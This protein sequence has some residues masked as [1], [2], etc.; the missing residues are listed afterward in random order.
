MSK[1]F[2]SYDI[3]QEKEE[4]EKIA[5]DAL[6]FIQA[7]NLG[8]VVEYSKRSSYKIDKSKLHLFPDLLGKAL[9]SLKTTCSTF[10]GARGQKV[11]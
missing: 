3:I 7:N 10:G 4:A 2:I 9:R 5:S 11:G 1:P 8:H 6:E